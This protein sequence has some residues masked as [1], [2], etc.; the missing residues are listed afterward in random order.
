MGFLPGDA[1]AHNRRDVEDLEVESPQRRGEDA[2]LVEQGEPRRDDHRRHPFHAADAPARLEE[3]E[4]LDA[5]DEPEPPGE[6]L[7]LLEDVD[8]RHGIDATGFWPREALRKR[9]ES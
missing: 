1:A 5:Y 3:L 2:D 4:R 9:A 7:Q 6:L 8:R